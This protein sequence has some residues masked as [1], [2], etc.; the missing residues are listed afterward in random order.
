MP[1]AAI[2]A[3]PTSRR[4]GGPPGRVDG[5]WQVNVPLTRNNDLPYDSHRPSFVT[6]KGWRYGWFER[7]LMRGILP[8]DEDGGGDGK[9]QVNVPLAR[10]NDLPYGSHRPSFVTHKGPRYRALRRF[11]GIPGH[12]RVR[13]RRTSSTRRHPQGVALHEVA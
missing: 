9:W 10:N 11:Q 8:V 6:H 12:W 1:C 13:L 7:A 3:S 4:G 5:K 2:I